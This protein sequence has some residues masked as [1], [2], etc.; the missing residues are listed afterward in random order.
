MTKTL[1]LAA[2]LSLCTSSAPAQIPSATPTPV[3]SAAITTHP[4]FTGTWNLNLAKSDFDQIPPPARETLVLIQTDSH[5][6][7][8]VTSDSDR[9]KEN[10][11]LAFPTDGTD[12]PTP[13]DT[14]PTTAELQILSSKGEWK[15][16]SFVFTEKITYQGNPGTLTST[17]TLSPDGKIL[18]RVMHISVD[19]GDF[20]TTSV[21]EK[22]P[23]NASN[24]V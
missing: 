19:Q 10:Y 3:P 7:V 4:D 12:T 20:D 11:T 6:T 24:P 2:A 8:A 21:F 22:Q 23:A 17:F 1:C 16:A 13:K 5:L 14:I 9:S 15:G 18:T